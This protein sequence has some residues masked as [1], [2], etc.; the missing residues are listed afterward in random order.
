MLSSYGAEKKNSCRLTSP[1]SIFSSI[2]LYFMLDF[3]QG[4]PVENNVSGEQYQMNDVQLT[5]SLNLPELDINRN[6]AMQ[7]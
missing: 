4:T 3:C 5:L 1:Q 7:I 6:I 2:S